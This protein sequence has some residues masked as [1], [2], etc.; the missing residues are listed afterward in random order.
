M[1]SLITLNVINQGAKSEALTIHEMLLGTAV[2][3]VN[4]SKGANRCYR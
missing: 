1:D 4:G 3:A 2:N